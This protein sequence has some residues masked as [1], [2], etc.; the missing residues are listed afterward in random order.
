MKQKNLILTI[1]HG[2]DYPFVEPFI[3]S[4]KN[5]GYTD[6][7]V[8]F[9]SDNISKATKKKLR[10]QGAILIEYNSVYPF[11]DSYK[12][13]FENIDPSVTINNYRFILFLHF[14]KEN[15]H[16]YQKVMLT[17]IRD[18][19]F[20]KPSF[21]DI[22]NKIYF[23]LEDGSQ[24]FKNSELNYNWLSEAAGT[25]FAD[26]ILNEIVSCA[27]VV[28]GRTNLVIAYLEYMKAK[29]SFRNKIKWGLDQGIHN[30]Y[31]YQDKP[32]QVELI[33]NNQPLV[34]TLG[35]CTIYNLTKNGVLI[36]PD[37]RIYPIVHQYDRIGELFIYFKK[38]YI[39]TR[40]TQIFKRLL[41]TLLP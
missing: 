31:A 11:I 1:M 36:N 26:S 8:I 29:L 20:Q 28:I 3:K 23:F 38:K 17:D 9:T 21:D 34:L 12:G 40:F 33:S 16:N 7:L 37:G 24:T 27:G 35:A 19:I 6:D 30:S 22:S 18:V 25:E 14:L 15:G 5:T 4:L 13:S 10:Q 2:Y 39:G 41:Y 32:D